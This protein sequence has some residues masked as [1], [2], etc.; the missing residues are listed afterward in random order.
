MSILQGACLE[1]AEVF[2]PQIMREPKV[3]PA[4]TCP[5]Q[6][7]GRTW[8]GSIDVPDR[9]HVDAYVAQCIG[10]MSCGL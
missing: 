8:L 7:R 4:S 2:Y 10:Y 5:V 9:S 3:L 6:D 1:V